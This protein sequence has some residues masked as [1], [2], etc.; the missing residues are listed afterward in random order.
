MSETT[1]ETAPE[2]PVTE[3]PAAPA[4]LPE[5]RYEYQPVDPQGRPV[6][7][8]QVIKYRTAQELGD[9][10][11]E[12]NKL[13][14][15]KLREET[16][17]N[18]LGIVE[19]ETL[20]DEAPR[21]QGPVTFTRRKL[22]PEERVKLSRDLLDPEK[23]DE[24]SDTLFE[25]TV[26]AKP[27]VLGETLSTLQQQVIAAQAKI[28]CD[29]FVADNP[30][31]VKCHENFEAIT[32][33]MLRYNLAPVKANFQKAYET[34]RRDGLLLE[35]SYEP[36]SAP[37]PVGVPQPEPVVVPPAPAPVEP[38]TPV[39]PVEAPPEPPKPA[40]TPRI[41]T[42][43]NRN[44]SDDAG[45]P[46]SAGDDIVYEV[47]TNGQK[48]RYTG[49]AAVNAMPSDEYKRRVI[50]DPNFGRKVEQLEKEA[51]ERRQSARR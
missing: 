50:S 26:G 25:A 41:P 42:G 34:L 9:K 44:T 20:P 49:L 28:E 38:P 4:E 2:V 8:K 10:L 3:T 12:Q 37:E 45:A 43:L 40:P 18:R 17:K 39:A 47:V 21:F 36:V 1:L 11:A 51:A 29:A 24:A 31:Y 23:F 16:K 32:N 46:R 5:L 6:G 30:A 13:L 48:R 15:L 22:S 35:S 33:W 7:G 14:I 19:Q 27:E